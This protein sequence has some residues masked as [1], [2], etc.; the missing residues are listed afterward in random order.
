MSIAA[1]SSSSPITA[2]LDVQSRT[3]RARDGRTH[4]ALFL[5]RCRAWLAL[6][7]VLGVLSCGLRIIW[8][9]A[10]GGTDQNG[11]LVSARLLLETRGLY[12]VPADPFQFV[13]NM[14]ILTPDGRVFAKYPPGYPLLAGLARMASPDG[15]YWINPLCTLLACAWSYLLF[16]LLLGRFAALV[17][18]IWMVSNPVVLF[19]GNDSNS[20]A[21]T[22]LCVVIGF[23]GLIHW[24][25]GN[26]RWRGL[27]GA[28]ALG[29]AATIRYSEA[30]L[31]LPVLFAAVLPFFCRRRSFRDSAWLILA[32]S[33]P[34]G[35]LA[36]VCWRSFGAPW[37]TGYSYCAEDTGF[38]WKYFWGDAAH[39]RQAHWET[40]IVQMNWIGLFM[41]WPLGIG[42]LIAI[43]GRRRNVGILLLLWVVPTTLL[44]L[45]YYW[46]PDAETSLGYLR[47][48]VSILPALI[49]SALW[50][51]QRGLNTERM[52]GKLALA[53][54]TA[55]ALLINIRNVA[56]DLEAS[57]V[58]KTELL[59]MSRFID[60]KVPAG[61][62]LFLADDEL[63]NNLD[64][65]GSFL[66]Y[67]LRWFSNASL[68]GIE[69]AL[70][71]PRKQGEPDPRQRTR[72]QTYLSLLS[73][74]GLAAKI[75]PRPNHELKEIEA[76]IMHRYRAAGRPVYALLRTGQNMELLPDRAAVPCR[77]LYSRVVFPNPITQNH[78]VAGFTLHGHTGNADPALGP[79][80]KWTLLEVLP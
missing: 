4:L 56:P 28:F 63:S 23:W 67:D 8:V 73:R 40:L 68:P 52:G 79:S 6:A 10:H 25:R 53:L 45:L 71:D 31:L 38:A 5:V 41:L 44:Y 13:G 11:Y 69:R 12:F 24:L 50:V 64:V 65:E 16:R 36:L 37:R 42:G 77:P 51:A 21:S 18:V 29:Y 30:L 78:P 54:V 20:H 3:R 26:G 72:L 46:A 66:L 48:F 80:V 9:P 15:A 74:Q 61:S 33:I 19:Y 75:A 39:G 2:L 1:N 22:L 55:F 62:V 76:S 32:W 17:G 47:F 34:V 27:L 70:D 49:L 43:V 7:I 59:E 14:M 60:A 35:M 58:R 57:L